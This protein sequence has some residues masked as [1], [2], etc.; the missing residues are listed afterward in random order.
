MVE[1]QSSVIRFGIRGRGFNR[2]DRSFPHVRGPP[3]EISAR[4]PAHTL[5]HVRTCVRSFV[6]LF[7]A[8]AS[9]LL[10]SEYNANVLTCRPAG[11]SCLTHRPHRVDLV[12]RKKGE[13]RIH[14][15]VYF[16]P[17]SSL[18]H[19]LDD[20]LRFL[21]PVLPRSFVNKQAKPKVGS[22]W[23]DTPVS[24]S[25]RD[26]EIIQTRTRNVLFHTFWNHRSLFISISL[27]K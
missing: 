7:I 18:L 3:S 8:C 13:T 23:S 26:N 25:P 5:L 27:R 14:S 10:C 1:W 19:H 11:K 4:A 16:E 9:R 15:G 2:T 22:V 17:D 20:S 24:T 21:S 6:C 12:K